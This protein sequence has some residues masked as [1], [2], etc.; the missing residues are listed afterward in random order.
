[1]TIDIEN[2]KLIIIFQ[3]NPIFIEIIKA[4]PDRKFIKNNKNWSVPIIHVKTVLD[5]L[6]PLNF[7]AT[8]IVQNEY[9]KDAKYR[10]K[11]DKIKNGE[12]KT[13][14][15]LLLTQTNLPLYDYQKIG[16]GFLCIVGSGLLGDAPGTGKSITSLAATLIN[17]SKKNLI[18]CP[19]SMKRQWQ[20]EICKWIPSCKIYLVKGSKQQR[21]ES[22]EKAQQETEMFFLII[23]YE[24]IRIDVEKLQKF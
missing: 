9:I 16:A 7:I 14:E 12:L 4:F 18:V 11:I 6:L 5:T 3:Y 10:Q 20:D 24:L 19:S 15:L 13:S 8:D 17:K 22:Y 21:E 23:N 2:K 1:M